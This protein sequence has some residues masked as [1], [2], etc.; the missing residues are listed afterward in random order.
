MI[1]ITGADGHLGTAVIEN[2]LK[3]TEAPKI[4][5]MVRNEAKG[6][7]LKEKGVTIRIGDYGDTD[8]LLKAFE[9]IEKLL[10]ISSNG[11]DA[12]GDHRNVIDAAKKVGIKYIAY[13]S[14]ALNAT[15]EISHL[16]HLY[17]SYITTENLIKESG[18]DYTI[19]QNCL[20]SETIPFFVGE[21]V[22]ETGINFP[23]QEGKASF[24]T[25]KDMGEAIANVL[26][27]NDHKNTTYI[28]AQ[29]ETYSFGDIAQILSKLSGRDVSYYSPDPLEYQEQLKSYGVSEEDI[30]FAALFADIIRNNEYDVKSKDLEKLLGRNP[31]DIKSYLAETFIA[32]KK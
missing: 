11:N 19:F 32:S 3:Q 31:Q 13:T 30:Y 4:V 2:L 24:A 9:G 22:L 10:L 17:D 21:Q 16:G 15:V 6:N 27:S 8:S 7:A 14:G 12:L 29:N 1:L 28:L 25:R 5:A 18:I 23:A 26:A 20:Y